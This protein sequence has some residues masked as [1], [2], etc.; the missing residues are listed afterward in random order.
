M[1]GGGGVW[2][3]VGQAVG[4]LVSNR[5]QK[6][7][8]NQAMREQMH[9]QDFMS[10]T[11]HQ[12][13][14]QDLRRAGLNPILSAT[15]GSGSPMGFGSAPTT[16]PGNVIASAME[17]KKMSEEIENLKVANENIEA[18]TTK[19]RQ[20]AALASAQHNREQAATNVLNQDE[21][22]RQQ[23]TATERW[24]TLAEQAQAG[25]LASTAKGAKLEGQIDESRFG[26]AMRYIDRTVRSLTGGS[27]AYRNLFR[28]R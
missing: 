20:E 14:V 11:A 6:V 23:Q 10:S 7:F 12:R 25:I 27:S 18:D 4:Q 3:A 17:G 2:G 5:Q 1:S 21:A 26:E 28:Q 9:F 15:G 19:K 16:N 13:E 24:R 8:A 22:L